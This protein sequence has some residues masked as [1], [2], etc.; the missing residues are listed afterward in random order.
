[1]RNGPKG[2]TIARAMRGSDHGTMGRVLGRHLIGGRWSAPKVRCSA[3]G[4][5]GSPSQSVPFASY[6]RP[7]RLGGVT[8]RALSALTENLRWFMAIGGTGVQPR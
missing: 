1:M 6:L 4:D 7:L 2:E 3:C 5:S 8:G